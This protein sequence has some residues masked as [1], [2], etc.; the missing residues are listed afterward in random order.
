LLLLPLFARLLPA[1]QLPQASALTFKTDVFANPVEVARKTA[2]PPAPTARV[3]LNLLLTLLWATG[4]A[5]GLAQMLIGWLTL[6]RLRSQARAFAPLENGITL[7]ESPAGT[8]P[9]AYGLF[10]PTIFLPEDAHQW[11]PARLKV[12][13][14]HERAH[15]QRR[16]PATHILARLALSLYWW[17]PL[18]WFAWREFLKEQ[19]SATDDLVLAQGTPATEYAEHLLHIARALQPALTG[20]AV[21]MLNKSQLTARMEAILDTTRNRATPRKAL[22][23]ASIAAA[24]LLMTPLAAMQTEPAQV[25]L[26]RGIAD[27]EAK[28]NQAALADLE[29]ARA[30]DSKVEAAALLWEAIAQLNLKNTEQAEKLFEGAVANGD[31]HSIDTAAAMEIYSR[32]LDSQGERDHAQTMREKAAEIRKSQAPALIQQ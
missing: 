8:M 11:P 7:L 27:L 1:L 21:A 20:P 12:V 16:D 26:T 31:P 24:I 25:Y 13:L 5:I 23:L 10:R 17:N 6:E 2:A 28:N 15:V 22:V 9:M 29:Q 30:H 14:R 4:T 18:A 32:F 19:E 3:S